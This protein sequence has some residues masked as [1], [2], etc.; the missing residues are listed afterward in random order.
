MNAKVGCCGFTEAHHK[1]FA[2][3]NVVEIQ[4]SFYQPP[5]LSVAKKWADQAPDG[6]EYTIKAWQLITH[7]ASSP[8]Y[9][10]LKQ[11]IPHRLK[12]RYGNFLPTREVFR[13][14]EILKNFAN[15]LGAKVIVFQCP[16]YFKPTEENVENMRNFFA[17]IDR[18]EFRF[19]METQENWDKK[20]VEKVCTEMNL[21]HATDPLSSE[22]HPAPIQY[23]RLHGVRGRRY[24]YTDDDLQKLK[25][26]CTHCELAY[27]LFNN[28]TM[29]DDAIR[30]KKLMCD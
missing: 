5:S 21:I 19:V 27:F 24:Q 29:R 28:A 26:L 7:K 22:L 16:N 23:F 11:P 4:N 25:E 30:F 12:P 17:G 6:F 18:G 20:S 15:V 8:S 13:A 14:W 2:H 1:Y 9:R 10:R 3:F